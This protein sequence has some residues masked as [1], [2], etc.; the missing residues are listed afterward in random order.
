[1]KPKCILI[2]LLILF[3]FFSKA[4]THYK[5]GY[6]ITINGQTIRGFINEKEWD[7][8]PTVINFKTTLNEAEVKNFTP[9]DITYFEII[10]SVAYQRYSGF[11][12]TDE[13]NISKLSR[14]RDSSKKQDIIFLKLQQKG[15]NVSLYSYNDAIKM[16]Y[17]IADNKAGT[18]FELLFKQYFIPDMGP[19]THIENE[20]IPQLYDLGTKYNPSSTELKQEIE[21]ASYK[22]PVLRKISQMI[23]D[24]PVDNTHYETLSS[25]DFFIGA[26]VSGSKFKFGGELPF[27]NATDSKTTYGPTFSAGVNFY[28]NAKIGRA[29]FRAELMYW[30]SSN[31]TM[32]D[33]YYGQPDKPKIKYHFDQRNITAYPQFIYYLYNN[34]AVKFYGGIGI[35]VSFAKYTQV[36]SST[37][38]SASN[39][40]LLSFDKNWL[41]FPIRT[42]LIINKA[43]EINASYAIPATINSGDKTS[44]NYSIKQ[45]SFKAGINYHFLIN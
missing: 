33:L 32:A 42:G 18:T 22:T 40:N 41:G 38:T 7:A 11:V 12:S 15:P 27:R 24:M 45:G 43:F 35:T 9:N 3:S 37:S 21:Q 30:T 8:N 29:V 23:N 20:F 19:V 14:G 26:G 36:I 16:R 39:N 5:P 4:Q 44:G 28:T 25:F 2:S 34:N 10:N 6:V 31:E 1:M 13:T 17:F